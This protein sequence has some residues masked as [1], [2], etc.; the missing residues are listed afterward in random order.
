MHTASD[1]AAPTPPPRPAMTLDVLDG[2][3]VTDTCTLDEFV[4]A[5]EWLADEEIDA[6]A[7]LAMGE[8][9]TGG[10]GAGALWAVRRAS[11]PTP[12]PRRPRATVLP[13]GADGPHLR[14]PGA[15]Y[16]S[17]SDHEINGRTA[18]ALGVA[19]F[20]VTVW[21]PSYGTAPTVYRVERVWADDAGPDMTSSQVEAWIAAHP[22][23][24]A[25]ITEHLCDRGADAD[26][27]RREL[28]GWR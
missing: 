8:V 7:A 14:H 26:E 15:L 6:I 1:F 2:D 24:A 11:S 23:L 21:L 18:E 9:Y 28:G 22:D 12:A 10:G 27:Q 16:L 20:E 5:N 3:C 25:D 13:P 17:G 4:R 19:G